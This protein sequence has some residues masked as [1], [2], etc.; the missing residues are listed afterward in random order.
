MIE[1][2][3][4]AEEL[5]RLLSILGIILGCLIIA[6]LFASIVV[7][8][9]RNANKPETPTAIAPVVGEAGWLDPTEFPPQKGVV[10]PPVD[11]K[12]LI[13][14]TPEL[15]SKGKTLFEANCASC[16]GSSGR[17]DGPAASTMKPRPR[18]L[19][20]SGGWINGYGLPGVFKTLSE[21]IRG[22]S[23]A[24]FDYLSKKDRMAM[25]HYVQSLSSF[26]KQENPQAIAAL[27]NEL[28]SAGE[29]I[30][31][32]IPVGMAMGKLEGEFAGAPSLAVDA[33]DSS[34]GAQILRRMIVD[35]SRAAQTLAQTQFWRTS[36][37]DLASAI[38][39]DLP[40]NGFSV[41]AA[42]LSPSEWQLFHS[43]LRNRIKV[44]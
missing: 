12:T 32:K 29:K 3:V 35:P 19:A 18:N 38:L 9:L 23:M 13:G 37:R 20:S 44:K 36:V 16:H 21:G 25:A 4:D 14:A 30:P 1:K 8:G 10:I 6:A 11:P 5:M 2:Y 40:G 22:T 31:N 7:S 39:L 33:K 26:E 34:P 42:T 24:P 15:L 43:E 27:S 28:G 17:G 41:S